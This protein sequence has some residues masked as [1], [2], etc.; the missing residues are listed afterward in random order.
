MHCN[1]WHDENLCRTNL[2]DQRLTR[3]IRINKSHREIC[4]FTVIIMQGEPFA[5]GIR[6]IAIAKFP[7]FTTLL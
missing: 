2:C 1:I 6:Y 7:S 5:H 4:C 3:I